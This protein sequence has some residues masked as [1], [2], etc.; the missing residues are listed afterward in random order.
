MTNGLFHYEAPQDTALPYGVMFIV[1]DVPQLT[2][3]EE[4]ENYLVQFNVFSD[5]R[6]HTEILDIESKM[7]TVFDLAEITVS[8]YN[9]IYMLRTMSTVFRVENEWQLTMTY[10][11]EIQKSR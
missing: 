3:T 10:R 8:G 6:S 7:K 9:H 11:C 2:F 5:T 4:G 1:S